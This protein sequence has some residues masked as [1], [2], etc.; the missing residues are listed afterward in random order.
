MN[1][2]AVACGG[3]AFVS[4]CSP[5]EPARDVADDDLTITTR[6]LRAIE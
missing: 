6:D 3:V 5:A 4:A 2:R 1:S